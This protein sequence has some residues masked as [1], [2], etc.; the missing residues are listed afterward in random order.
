MIDYMGWIGT[1]IMA[2]GSIGI[3]HKKAFGLWLMLLGNIIWLGVGVASG[4][5]SLVGVSILMGALDYYGIHKWS[6]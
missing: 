2:V 5:S 1:L 3:A 4:L 6:E